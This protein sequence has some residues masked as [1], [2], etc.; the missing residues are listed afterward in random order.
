VLVVLPPGVLRSCWLRSSSS[1]GHARG[2]TGLDVDVVVVETHTW[3]PSRR[4]RNVWRLQ[5]R[6]RPPSATHRSIAVPQESRHSL[7]REIAADSPAGHPSVTTTIQTIARRV[8]MV[9]A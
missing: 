7:R 5:R 2:R 8:F 3:S 4:R 1:P 6:R 9:R